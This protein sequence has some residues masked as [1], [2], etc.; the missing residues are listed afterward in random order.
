MNVK[1]PIRRRMLDLRNSMLPETV[2]HLSAEVGRHFL[3]EIGRL[4]TTEEHEKIDPLQAIGLYASTQ[5]EVETDPIFLSLKQQGA[6][7][8]I[9]KIK[10]FYPRVDN[11]GDI[12]G[13]MQ[14]FPLETLSDLAVGRWNIREPKPIT[15]QIPTPMSDLDL[16]VLPGV[17]FDEQGHRL[18][19]GKGYYD[20]ALASYEG[21]KVGLAYEF[22]ILKDVPWGEHDVTC[23]WIVTEKRLIQTKC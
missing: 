8:E 3:S 23:D 6:I 7:G 21:V 1:E 5:N 19:M 17:A 13:A 10:I 2:R 14:F 11:G 22:Q 20:R 16:V 15:N 4:K 9:G 12:G 18:G